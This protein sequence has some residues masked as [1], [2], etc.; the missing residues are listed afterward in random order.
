MIKFACGESGGRARGGVAGS[1]RPPDDVLAARNIAPARQT[2]DQPKRNL[3][4]LGRPGPTGV[5][6]RRWSHFIAALWGSK[7]VLP[8][9]SYL[10]V[11]NSRLLRLVVLGARTR[12]MARRARR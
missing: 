11:M 9:S 7:L 10:G 3:A 12:S 4:T 5:V 8:T 6:S 1:E 2:I